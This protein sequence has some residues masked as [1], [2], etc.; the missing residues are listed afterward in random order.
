MNREQP[1]NENP[2]YENLPYCFDDGGRVAAGFKGMVGDCLTRAVAIVTSNPYR[3]VYKALYKLN[4]EYATVC[5]NELAQRMR[6]A[7]ESRQYHSVSHP[8]PR[9]G[10][11]EDV[12]SDYLRDYGWYWNF[13]IPDESGQPFF[14]LEDLH[15]CEGRYIINIDAVHLDTLQKYTGGHSI[16]VIDG[17]THDVFNSDEFHPIPVRSFFAQFNAPIHKVATPPHIQRRIDEANVQMRGASE[18]QKMP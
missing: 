17:Q 16:A 4:I 12:A 6:T 8:S 2:F 1:D 10:L 15:G 11:S 14:F 7:M 3:E 5:E 13:T 9:T 18:V